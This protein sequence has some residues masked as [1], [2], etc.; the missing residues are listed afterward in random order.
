MAAYNG[1][2]P[3]TAAD[4]LRQAVAQKYVFSN[5]SLSLS[6]SERSTGVMFRNGLSSHLVLLETQRLFYYYQTLFPETVFSSDMAFHALRQAT[7]CLL[8]YDMIKGNDGLDRYHYVHGLILMQ[9][10][11]T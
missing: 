2:N 7:L 8:L 11:S 3:H 9:Q 6:L 10:R 5:L 4:L 1:V